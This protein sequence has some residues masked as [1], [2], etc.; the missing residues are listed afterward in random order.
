[1]RVTRLFTGSDKRSHFEEFELRWEATS[2]TVSRPD[3][4]PVIEASLR[5]TTPEANPDHLAFHNAPQR[6][7]MFILS[8]AAEIEVGDGTKRTFTAGD[9]VFV[10]DTTG[11]GHRLRTPG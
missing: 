10:E 4:P 6:Q 5:R 1:M 3:L 2:S 9:I 8:G 7:I 11:E